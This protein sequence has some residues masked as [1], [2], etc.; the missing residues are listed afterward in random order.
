MQGHQ[1]LP[2]DVDISHTLQESLITSSTLFSVSEADLEAASLI[3]MM[4]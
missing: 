2:R 4:C 3:F 1:E